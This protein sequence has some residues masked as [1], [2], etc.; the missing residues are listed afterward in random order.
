VL[1]DSEQLKLR[2][3]TYL[4]KD[5]RIW[6]EAVQKKKKKK[7]RTRGFNVSRIIYVYIYVLKCGV[8]GGWR[9]SVGPIM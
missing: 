9:R 6:F 3:W 8:G 4:V 7:K 1:N 2:N 5:R